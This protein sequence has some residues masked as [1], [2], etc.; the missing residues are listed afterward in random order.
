MLKGQVDEAFEHAVQLVGGQDRTRCTTQRVLAH[1]CIKALNVHQ[2]AGKPE[3]HLHLI[4]A[5]G[6]EFAL[7]T[8]ESQG[9]IQI[10]AQPGGKWLDPVFPIAQIAATSH[11]VVQGLRITGRLGK[12]FATGPFEQSVQKCT[13]PRAPRETVNPGPCRQGF[14]FAFLLQIGFQRSCRLKAET[15]L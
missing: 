2:P 10:A 7:G 5:Q 11:R 6:R 1:Q 9:R 12:T 14:S 4:G 8:V 15:R 3:L 13:R